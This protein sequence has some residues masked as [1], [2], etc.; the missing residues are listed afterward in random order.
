M[1]QQGK[2]DLCPQIYCPTLIELQAQVKLLLSQDAERRLRV[3]GLEDR[4]GGLETR[5]DVLAGKIGDLALAVEQ[6]IIGT[7]RAAWARFVLLVLAVLGAAFGM[8]AYMSQA[9][10]VHI[11]G[12]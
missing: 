9:L 12:R 6:R 7:E 10:W 3:E 11:A 8:T 2:R 4:I 1:E 5:L